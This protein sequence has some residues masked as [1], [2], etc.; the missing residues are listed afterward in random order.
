MNDLDTSPSNENKSQFT[1]ALAPPRVSLQFLFAWTTAVAV[2]MA[3]VMSV[4]RGVATEVQ[5]IGED[6][7][8]WVTAILLPSCV[9]NGACLASWLYFVKRWRG[10]PL[11]FPTQP[12]HWL[13]LWLGLKQLLLLLL[14]AIGMFVLQEVSFAWSVFSWLSL[15][16][17][18]IECGVWFVLFRAI[19][20]HLIWKWFCACMSA[21]CGFTALWQI[22]FQL[23]FNSMFMSSF[24]PIGLALQIPMAIAI[25]G[26]C[27]L[28][29]AA[30]GN[31]LWHRRKYDWLHWV[32][33]GTLFVTALLQAFVPF[34]G[35]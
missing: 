26:A 34:V 27:V 21:Y 2:L 12:G 3:L 5:S 4:V 29:I 28:A 31:D 1:P 18:M 24:S 35:F 13:A 32:G 7:L 22:G 33:V 25:L 14:Q 15:P 6:E 20:G 11:A 16:V 19:R 9:L 30:L 8:P 17:H 23:M 10:E